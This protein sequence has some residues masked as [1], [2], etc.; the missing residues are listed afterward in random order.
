MSEGGGVCV[1]R[2]FVT[3][4]FFFSPKFTVIVVKKRINARIFHNLQGELKN[5]PPGTVVDTEITKPEWCAGFPDQ[6]IL[7]DLWFSDF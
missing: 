4:F 2:L 1:V 7:V 6:S 5:P 3:Y